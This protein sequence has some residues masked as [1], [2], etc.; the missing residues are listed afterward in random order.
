LVIEFEFPV[1]SDVLIEYQGD[2]NVLWFDTCPK[3]QSIINSS[4]A[5]YGAPSWYGFRCTP[6]ED[7]KYKYS[8]TF[9]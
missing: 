5:P 8:V 6:L 2:G 3:W 4:W 1:N 7:S 9:E